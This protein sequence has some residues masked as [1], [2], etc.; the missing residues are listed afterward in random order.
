MRS[1]APTL[2]AALVA[3]LGVY[4]GMALRDGCVW[5]F[6]PTLR[7]LTRSENPAGYWTVLGAAALALTILVGI[8]A[9]AL[10]KL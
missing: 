5:L 1:A 8:M 4:I 6:F 9:Y 3:A 2:W 7:V 10:I